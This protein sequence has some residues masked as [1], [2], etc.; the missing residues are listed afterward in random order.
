M[1]IK[2]AIEILQNAR[3]RSKATYIHPEADFVVSTQEAI[4]ECEALQFA[5]NLMQEVA[6]G[7]RPLLPLRIED[8]VYLLSADK[9]R[10]YDA[11]IVNM[12]W[13]YHPS[14][15]MIKG[16]CDEVGMMFDFDAEE[17]GKTVFLTREAAEKALEAG[18]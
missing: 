10:V 15:M 14:R 12:S 5:I 3:N 16:Y 18:K 2:E 13:E 8:T 11:V 17:L 4:E 6:D 1:E 7:R 9:T